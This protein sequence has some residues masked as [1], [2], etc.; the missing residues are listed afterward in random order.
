[1]AARVSSIAPWV[2]EIGDGQDPPY[3][4]KIPIPNRFNIWKG[5]KDSKMMVEPLMFV[6]HGIVKNLMLKASQLRKALSL[7]VDEFNLAPI[8]TLMF[9]L[10]I[11][12]PKHNDYYSI[13]L[14]VVEGI[15]GSTF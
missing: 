12:P 9:V 6:W 8:I 7:R 1:M 4:H 2:G 15:L 14:P 11:Q 13:V 5:T 10:T 3:A